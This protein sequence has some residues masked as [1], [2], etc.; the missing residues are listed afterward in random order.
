MDIEQLNKIKIPNWILVLSFFSG[1]IAPA[2]LFIFL[3]NRTLFITLDF[4]KLFLLG[5][6]IALSV[7]IA[8]TSSILAG[9]SL[10]HGR[11]F[12]DE[13]ESTFILFARLGNVFCGLTFLTLIVLTRITQEIEGVKECIL[14]LLKIQVG[15]IIFMAVAELIDKMK[16]KP[17]K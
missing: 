6:S 17:K 9:Y 2:F 14:L 12:K 13:N 11:Q 4:W 1:V 7:W 16:N 10:V 5:I 3:Y 15:T 8:T